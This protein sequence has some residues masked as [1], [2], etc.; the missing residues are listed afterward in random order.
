MNVENKVILTVA[1]TGAYGTK[2]DNPYIPIHPEEIANEVYSCYKAGASIAHIHVRDED[3]QGSMDLEKFEKTVSLIR[4]RCDIVLNITTSGSINAT[5]EERIKPFMMLR[6][7]IA[8]FDCGS[9]NWG[10][11]GIFQ[12]SP[13]FLTMLGQKMKECEVK[14][15]IE[16]FDTGM[17]SNAQ[18]YLKN[19]VLESPPH[20]QFVLG[21]AGGMPATIDNLLYLKNLLPKNATWSAFGIGKMNLPIM[22]AT[23][24]LGGHIRV[25]MEDNL[26]YS[27]GRLATSNVEFVERAKRIINEAD[28]EVATPDEARRILSLHQHLETNR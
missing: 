1:P 4:E 13:Q 8:S 16:I 24:A 18:F 14:P 12:N 5:D 3:G 25:G 21:V 11:L 6:P 20:F 7:E 17:M 27:K 10:Q 23:I 22:L 26:Y 2:K 28:K 15:E 9:I 19:G